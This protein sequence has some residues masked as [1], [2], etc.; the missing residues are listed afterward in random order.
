LVQ[1]QS[2]LATIQAAGITLV[3]ISYDTPELL[4]KF[5]GE[6]S[7]SFP[8]LSDAGS[9]TVD[10][11]QLRDPSGNGYPFPVTYVIGKDGVVQDKLSLSGYRNRHTTQALLDAVKAIAP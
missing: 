10:A 2:D 5:A 7:I 9:A 6:K 8:L 11:Y 4:A 1:L 3:A